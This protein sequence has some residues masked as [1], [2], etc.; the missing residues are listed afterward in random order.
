MS[1]GSARR[2]ALLIVNPKARNG[3]TPPDAL[4]AALTEGGLDLVEPAPDTPCAEAIA[5]E[6]G[7]AELV[8][9]GGGDGTMNAAAPALVA[10]GLPLAILPLGTANDLAR[11]LGIPLD[12]VAAARL[13]AS[14]EARPVD[15]GWVNGHYYFNVASVGFSAELAG[16]LTAESK[17]KWGTLGYGIAAIR[18][19]RRVRPFT[20]TIEHDGTVEKVTTIQVSVGNGRHYGGG[21][22]VEADATVD[23]GKLDFYSLEVAHWWRL[24]ALLPALRRG[25]HGRSE[26]VRAFSTTEIVLRTKR[27]R[28]VNT[29]G[30]LTTSTPAH[31]KVMPKA[32]RIVAPPRSQRPGVPSPHPL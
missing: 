24:I 14:E 2:R 17:K 1:A 29:D 23:D 28:P 30:E 19:L 32:V 25:T 8:I 31:F 26:D 9:L 22:T 16:D 21:M 7:R 11:S 13:A 6:A 3:G 10:T 15:L 12:P 4:R 27:P 18:V 20:V 5:A